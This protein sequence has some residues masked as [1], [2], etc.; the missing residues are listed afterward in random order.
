MVLYG[1]V[2]TPICTVSLKVCVCEGERVSEC[3][4]PALMQ[5]TSSE[6]EPRVRVTQ[7]NT[8]AEV[9][10]DQRD[11]WSWAVRARDDHWQLHGILTEC[12]SFSKCHF[13]RL[14]FRQATIP[15]VGPPPLY[16]CLFPFS[17]LLQPLRPQWEASDMDGFYDQQVPFMVPPSVRLCFDLS[18]LIF[19]T[20]VTVMF[21]YR[22]CGWLYTTVACSNVHYSISV[23]FYRSLTCRNHLAGLSMTEKGSL[24]TPSWHRILRVNKRTST[25]FNPGPNK[26]ACLFTNQSFL[27][28]RA[29]SRSQPAT[30]DLDSRRY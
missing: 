11:S 27:F 6:R 13:S 25:S 5:H 22:M 19:F 8:L 29:L 21:Y 26:W 18:C 28:H 24:L 4:R 30:R 23:S 20:F 9:F 14:F 10:T 16:P 3:K 2:R 17:L 7:T 1:Y 15:P 12:L